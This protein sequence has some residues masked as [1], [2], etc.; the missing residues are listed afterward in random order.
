MF[1]T[2]N[3]Y[4]LFIK[5]NWVC[6]MTRYHAEPNINLIDKKFVNDTIAL[7]VGLNRRIERMINLNVT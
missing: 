4:L 5:E 1:W 7:F 2:S 3:L 6:A